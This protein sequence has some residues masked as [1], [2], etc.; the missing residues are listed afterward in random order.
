MSKQWR[1]IFAVVL[2]VLLLAACDGYVVTPQTKLATTTVT[3]ESSVTPTLDPTTTL[4]PTIGPTPVGGSS[5][6]VFGLQKRSGEGFEDLGVYLFDMNTKQLTQIAPE[7]WNIQDAYRDGRKLL[8]NRG[9]EL[10]ISNWNASDSQLL[11][12]DLFYFGQVSAAFYQDHRTMY[13]IAYV[14]GTE[15]GTAILFKS[16]DES[17]PR[18]I[19][20]SCNKPI[21]ILLPFRGYILYWISGSCIAEGL[22]IKDQIWSTRHYI[23]DN[24]IPVDINH[25][26]LEDI[27]TARPYVADLAVAYEYLDQEGRSELI[28]EGLCCEE[29]Q[30]YH[31]IEL[32][33]ET[34]VDFA[35]SSR[36]PTLAIIDYDRS[37]YS[38]RVSGTRVFLYDISSSVPI[39]LPEVAGLNNR[40]LWSPDGTF[41]LFTATELTDTGSRILLSTLRLS[42]LLPTDYSDAVNLTSSNELVITNIYW[43]SLPEAFK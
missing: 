29:S 34:L 28:W 6:I 18:T 12:S 8:I 36:E 15:K 4:T 32:P 41:L 21:E 5:R 38:G 14:A 40:V 37:D 26:Q 35:W 42:D 9:N 11:V 1:M 31:T 33:G 39:E 10:Y 17:S 30:G 25:S 19:V 27:Q 43:L 13:G 22:C 20:A 3:L 16:L 24:N 23:N 2:A 7:G